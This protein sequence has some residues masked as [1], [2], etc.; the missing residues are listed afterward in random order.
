[1]LVLVHGEVEA[2]KAPFARGPDVVQRIAFGEPRLAP[3]AH[4]FFCIQNKGDCEGGAQGHIERSAMLPGSALREIADI[5]ADVN[6]RIVPERN[7][8]GVAGEKW[9]LFP[10]RGDCNDYAVSKRHALLSRGWPSE[11]LLLAE[12][13]TTWGE[14]H[15]VLVVRSEGGD[16]VLD[17]LTDAILSWART[18]YRWVRI[19]SPRDPRF[20]LAVH[21][22]K[23]DLQRVASNARRSAKPRA[24]ADAE[25][26]EPTHNSPR[27]EDENKNAS[28]AAVVSAF[29]GASAHDNLEPL[30]IDSEV[31]ERVDERTP[32]KV[33]YGSDGLRGALPPFD[34]EQRL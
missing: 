6:A 7:N 10:A 29:A 26:R 4:T 8:E 18:P 20:W 19:Q 34:V 9:L 32:T 12:V 2:K 16:L 31:S 23:G 22:G 27:L 25:Q 13:V 11:A 21:D 33:L 30:R 15:L 3:L 28:A 17:S 14:H 24:R 5:N 1:M